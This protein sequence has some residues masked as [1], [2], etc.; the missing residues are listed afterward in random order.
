MNP[1]DYFDDINLSKPP[2]YSSAPLS[3]PPPYSSA[4][5]SISQEIRFL[6]LLPHFLKQGLSYNEVMH[7]LTLAC[8]KRD[9]LALDPLF[10]AYITSLMGTMGFKGM[11]RVN[12]SETDLET[13]MYERTS[14]RREWRTRAIVVISLWATVMVCVGWGSVQFAHLAA[15]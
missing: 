6:N 5:P 2:P 12:N 8:E 4:P 9:I 1:P 14:G 3:K 7:R 10:V 11:V 13:S 15:Q